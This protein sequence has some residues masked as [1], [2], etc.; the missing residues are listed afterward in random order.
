MATAPAT[1]RKNQA[2]LGA[3]EKRRLVAALLAV[4]KSGRYDD[5]VRIHL[6]MGQMH[7]TGPKRGQRKVPPRGMAGMGSMGQMIHG[8]PT[9][10]PWHRELLRRLE[11]DLQ[12][13]DSS[14]AIPYWNWAV[15]DSPTSSLWRP[16]FL[17]ADGREADRRVMDGPFAYD[18]GRWTLKYNQHPEPDLKRAFAV[19]ATVLPSAAEVRAC[20][21]ETP[22]DAAPWDTSSRPSFR[23]RLE[24]WIDAPA[25][26]EVG[27]HD[28]VHVWVGGTMSYMS[29]PND[30]VFFLHH[31]NIDRLWAQWQQA[32][33]GLD[34][35]PAR[36]GPEG[37]NRGD[38][39]DP[40]GAPATIASVLDHR[41]L[42]YRYDD[43]G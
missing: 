16:D 9:F 7:H 5:Y 14:V 17:G 28:L 20:L 24:G 6:N 39:L 30:P 8:N 40:W 31:A 13:V 21:G 10:L 27:M 19:D 36:G 4:K 42:G 37:E 1:I 12:A 15:D 32:H 29:S 34:Y 41:A 33:Q 38:A 26:Q 11:L 3:D 25:G 35:A 43:E 2:T 22:Y 18:A 23:N